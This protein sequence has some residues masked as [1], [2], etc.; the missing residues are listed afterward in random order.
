MVTDELLTSLGIEQALVT[1]LNEKGIP[2]P[3]A[4]VHLRAPMSRIGILTAVELNEKISA[5]QLFLKYNQAI[6]RDSAHELLKR[7]IEASTE[8]EGEAKE[9]T[10]SKNNKQPEKSI[11]EQARNNPFVKQVG[12]TLAREEARSLLGVLGFGSRKKKW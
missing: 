7:K 4:A 2:T 11:L 9:S 6:D 3:L 1:A 12:R 5:S 10:P 8:K